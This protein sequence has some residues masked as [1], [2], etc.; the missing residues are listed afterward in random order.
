[1]RLV[2]ASV[3][4]AIAFNAAALNTVLNTGTRG[5]AV[6][7]A[8]N[9]ALHVIFF[10]VGL[11]LKVTNC[12]GLYC[13]YST[14]V[15]GYLAYYGAFQAAYQYTTVG[16]L[17]GAFTS[18][19]YPG[20]VV[21]QLL[22]AIAY[23]VSICRCIK[24]HR[25]TVLPA[26]QV[27]FGL[28][29]IGIVILKVFIGLPGGMCND[30]ADFKIPS[31]DE[32]HRPSNITSQYLTMR[33][34]VR[35]AVDVYLPD[36][37][38]AS[39]PDSRMPTFVVLTRYHRRRVL[40]WPWMYVGFGG[41][42]PRPTFS[43]IM[44]KYA[45]IFVP[46]GYAC[47]AV[48]V[49][50]TGASFGRRDL[51]LSPVEIHDLGEVL[52]WIKRQEWCNGRVG[53]AGVSY[54]GIMAAM[55]AS[56]G[57]VDAVGLLFSPVDFVRDILIPGGVLNAEFVTLYDEM[58]TSLEKN[59][60]MSTGNVS[61]PFLFS[62]V[63]NYV[64]GGVV[65]VN[66]DE[67]SLQEALQEHEQNWDMQSGI[68]QFHGFPSEIKFNDHGT[69]VSID[70]VGFSPDRVQMLSQHNISYMAWAGHWDHASVRSA[71]RLYKLL[72]QP[73]MQL[74][75]GPWTH[76]GLSCYTPHSPGYKRSYPIL[77]DLF[78]SFDC[79]LRG[80]CA[81]GMERRK[82]FQYFQ[83]GEEK[84]RASEDF[85]PA[86]SQWQTY[87]LS[88]IHGLVTDKMAEDTFIIQHVV[89]NSTTTGFESRWNIASHI[90]GY[91]VT[92]PNRLDAD[93]QLLTFNSQPLI[94]DLSIV[95]SA[96]VNLT[97]ELNPGENATVFVYLEDVD[98][99]AGRIH[100]VT[101]GMLR[102]GHGVV[103]QNQAVGAWDSVERSYR[104]KDFV[105]PG[106]RNVVEIALLPMAYTFVS[107]HQVR[108]SF[109]GADVGNFDLFYLENVASSW[110]V[111]LDS[112]WLKLPVVPQ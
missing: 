75:F 92:Y 100:Y 84:W 21:V 15:A 43:P 77:E 20:T 39:G 37:W 40:H 10:S 58:T 8:L 29:F 71:L 13:V 25:A 17:H 48:D 45:S 88:A 54:D 64:I 49:R 91:T 35:L 67:E 47:V 41:D 94:S 24:E 56:H 111:H 2:A 109:A 57:G 102:V 32:I 11:I 23:I 103:R 27:I 72:G 18:T 1:M 38:T 63:F 46:Q 55:M 97:L 3:A 85:P 44:T 98:P 105:A 22:V 53:A 14:G 83:V 106:G 66:G 79:R 108:L 107:G 68:D 52:K 5:A 90:L 26:V 70:D 110:K 104:P 59:L 28:I 42:V 60:V 12:L 16:D 19:A 65:P 93:D 4:V 34:G 89:S 80:N 73:D 78:L 76:G 99:L 82:A 74:T 96:L 9:S 51:D 31:R 6:D 62:F 30:G 61:Q 86:N 33:D 50:G 112:A 7:P 81:A 36:G 95:G 87:Y 101:E 69:E